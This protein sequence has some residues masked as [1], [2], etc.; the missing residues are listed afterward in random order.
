MI[1]LTPA[2]GTIDLPSDGEIFNVNLSPAVGTIDLPTD[3]AVIELTAPPLSTMT[4]YTDWIYLVDENGLFL[5]DD[6]SD[7]LVYYETGLTRTN[8]IELKNG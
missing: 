8:V 4:N 7:N 5:V 6:I 2:I 3:T 1:D